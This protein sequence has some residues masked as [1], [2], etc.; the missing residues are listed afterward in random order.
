MSPRGKSATSTRQ[1]YSHLLPWGRGRTAKLTVREWRC[2]RE[3]AFVEVQLPFPCEPP[4]PFIRFV[5]CMPKYLASPIQPAQHASARR[6]LPTRLSLKSSLSYTC[7]PQR[8]VIRAQPCIRK[9]QGAAH[10]EEQANRARDR[11]LLG[12][13]AA[14]M[15][16]S[17][18]TSHT[19]QQHWTRTILVWR[20]TLAWRPSGRLAVC[21]SSRQSRLPAAPVRTVASES[22]VRRSPT[23][24]TS[25][26]T[27][28]D[29]RPGTVTAQDSTRSPP[30]SHRMSAY[31]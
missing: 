10:L 3:V 17:S 30:G 18:H 29:S 19:Q 11:R 15:Q 16:L 6:G 9:L 20:S 31:S 13:A 23:V 5:S 24:M 25:T 1:V 22:S 28:G 14:M 2:R 26:S 8:R 21:A 27:H 7:R 12:A 4:T